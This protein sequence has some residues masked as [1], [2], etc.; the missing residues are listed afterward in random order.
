MYRYNEMR[1]EIF[2]EHGFKMY[3]E[4]RTNIQK[5]LSLSG[6]FTVDKAIDKISGD[7]FLMLACIDYMIELKEITKVHEGNSTQENV[8]VKGM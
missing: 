1:N 4:I 6:A 8:Y 7:T 5:M 3:N 2:T